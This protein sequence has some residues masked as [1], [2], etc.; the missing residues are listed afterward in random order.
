MSTPYIG[1]S[2]ETL[3]NQPNVYKGDIIICPN[4]GGK[5]I[6]ECGQKKQD[7]GSM[8]DSDILL[9]YRCGDSTYLAAVANCLVIGVKADLSGE[10]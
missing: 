1:F 2:D 5:H 3:K 9:F 4:C 10:L 6:L 7:D 8:Q